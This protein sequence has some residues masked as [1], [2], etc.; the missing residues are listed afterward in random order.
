[1]DK[2]EQRFVGCPSV[3]RMKTSKAGFVVEIFCAFHAAQRIAQL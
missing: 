3:L 1:M 2:I